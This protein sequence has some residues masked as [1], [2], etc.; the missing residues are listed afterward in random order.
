MKMDNPIELTGALGEF[1]G[2]NAGEFRFYLDTPLSDGIS[3]SL[4]H[5]RIPPHGTYAVA[6]F[7]L[8]ASFAPQRQGIANQLTPEFS[9]IECSATLRE[10]CQE[11]WR[12]SLLDPDEGSDLGLMYASPSLFPT[13]SKRTPR[14]V[15]L[16][17]DSS[18]VTSVRKRKTT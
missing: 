11:S 14:V 15:T 16:R 17:F 9:R 1:E 12:F 7:D 8:T 5:S 6:F 10:G 3:L 4:A 2:P 18:T 13:G